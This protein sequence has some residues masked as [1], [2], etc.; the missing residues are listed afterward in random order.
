MTMASDPHA[1]W[2]PVSVDVSDACKRDQLIEQ[3]SQ[4]AVTMSHLDPAESRTTAPTSGVTPSHHEASRGLRARHD[5]LHLDRHG[6][7][8]TADPRQVKA[9]TNTA[10]VPIW[11]EPPPLSPSRLQRVSCLRHFS[12]EPLGPT[13]G[14]V[15]TRWAHEGFRADPP[16]GGDAAAV[17]SNSRSCSDPGMIGDATTLQPASVEPSHV[18]SGLALL[19]IALSELARGMRGLDVLRRS[20]DRAPPRLA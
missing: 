2:S 10:A 13:P 4:I 15:P 3:Q 12:G 14:G 17:E 6:Y 20:V 5:R 11:R 16:A 9:R 7:L 18:P 1:T 19:A 8:V